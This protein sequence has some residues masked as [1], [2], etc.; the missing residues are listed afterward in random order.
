MPQ[1]VFP[2]VKSLSRQAA[3]LLA[4]LSFVA[5]APRAF[6][7]GLTYVEANALL[8]PINLS[9]ET[10][11]N[12]G[13]ANTTD[14]KWGLRSNLGA[15]D[16]IYEAGLSNENSPEISQMIS[17]LTP[18]SSYDFYVVY[19]T[20]N[21]SATDWRIQTGMTSG[22]LTL[23]NNNGPTAATPSAQAG[24]FASSAVWDSAPE[25]GTLFTEDNRVMRV[26]LAG[27][28]V[29]DAMG[30]A[31]VYVDDL[32][33]T[34]SGFRSWFDGVAYAPAGTSLFL[35]STIDRATGAIAITNTT[36][37]SFDV[38]SYS[39]ASASGALSGVEW[40]PVTGNTDGTGSG[41]FDSDPWTIS[42]PA[43]PAATPFATAL[44]EGAAAGTGGALVSGGTLQLGNAWVRTP[45]QDVI[46]T[47]TLGDNSTITISPTYVNDSIV[48]GDFDGSGDIDVADYLALMTNIHAGVTGLT[49][50]EY[51]TRG[52]ITGDK[53]IDYSDFS[54]FASVYDSI[55]GSGSFNGMVAAVPEPNS[56]FMFAMGLLVVGVAIGRQRR[57]AII[58]SS[59]RALGI[60]A[61]CSVVV[62]SGVA[63][64]PAAPVVN[65]Q[66]DPLIGPAAMV[67]SNLETDSPTVGDGSAEN[68][69]NGAIYAEMPTVT[70]AR[71][72]QIT[73]TG[74]ATFVGINASNSFRYG[75]MNETGT[76]DTIGWYGYWT[77]GSSGGTNGSIVARDPDGTTFNTGTSFSTNS[78]TAHTLVT[79]GG[80]ALFSNDTYTF[81]MTVG[82]FNDDTTTAYATITSSSGYA[83]KLYRATETDPAN[84]TFSFNRV[85]LLAGSGL[86]ADQVQYGSISV[87]SGE[88]V[89]PKL[90]VNSSGAVSIVNS[91]GVP[92]DLKYYEIKSAS[93]G[94]NPSG[95]S[96]IDS[97]EG[98]DPFGQGWDEA[99]ASNSLLLSEGNL[100]GSTT[101]A[102]AQSISLGNAAVA[103]ASDLQFYYALPTGEIHRGMVEYVAGL[104][105]DFDNDGDVDGAD[106]VVWQ[107]NF[108]TSSGATAGDGDGDADVDGA[109]FALWQDGFPT[110]SGAGAAPV[111]E[112]AG[113]LLLT[114]AALAVMLTRRRR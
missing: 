10:A 39:I 4:V 111:P 13:A 46:V 67:L 19:W 41:A 87:T 74:S 99:A 105:G 91:T 33:G 1:L 85:G 63:S 37:Q 9:P 48:A 24:R 11:I 102:A 64:A 77:T 88:I 18:G 14:G 106:F 109:D 70:L 17:G 27:T 101:L 94:L 26:G 83:M 103:G 43:N 32:P 81:S 112:P 30:Q 7:V 61:S 90:T 100:Q 36:S 73:L 49:A 35:T 110:S 98:S 82:R 40:T 93:G 8:L 92:F 107:T 3:A 55:H 104:P 60:V 59:K 89:A 79:G 5:V 22:S 65:W 6:A 29:A 38:K 52:D 69:A 44:S 50:A 66:R 53:V 76:P 86:A 15:F 71:G 84:I 97:S 96:S 12:V 2:P 23:Y 80:P 42:A 51:Y 58:P 68:A 45:F 113:C 16:S 75:L 57:L 108:P 62:L 21:T 34:G 78:G 31:S 20:G 28:A 25:G 114:T 47:L 72:Q 56:I 54:T 95:W